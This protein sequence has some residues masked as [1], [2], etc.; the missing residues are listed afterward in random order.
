MIDRQANDKSL[1]F[2]DIFQAIHRGMMQRGRLL[3]LHTPLGENTLIPLRA[4][5]WSKVG[6]GYGWVVDVASTRNDIDG[7]ELMHQQVSLS[8]Q[9][10]TQIYA[11]VEYR[12]VHGFVR[13]FGSIGY[14]GGLSLYQLEFQSA[15]FFLEYARDENQWFDMTAR[16]IVSDLLNKYPQL[17]GR[18]RFALTRQPVKRSYTRQSETDLNFLHRILESEGWYFYWDHASTRHDDHFKGAT[19][20]V[21]DSVWSL[22]EAR[23]AEFYR[24]GESDGTDG[25]T[26]W[27]TMQTA[28]SM[29]YASTSTNYKNIEYP[30][31]I[32]RERDLST[33]TYTVRQYRS[34][35]V[36]SVPAA[37]ME[38]FESLSYGYPDSLAGNRHAKIRTEAW[39]SAAC[40][41]YGLGGM[42]WTDAGMRFTLENHPRHASADPNDREFVAIEV[43]SVIEN[44]IP[45]GHGAAY[46]LSL[47]DM[48]AT[49]K[50]IHGNRFDSQAH[51]VDGARG[52][53]L[54]EIEAQRTDLP[55]RSPL[56]HKKPDMH[57]EHALVCAPGNE[58][59]W[60]DGR[61]RIYVRFRWD[62]RSKPGDSRT[63][64]PLLSLQADTGNG[65]GS[66]HV[67]RAGEWVIV[68]FWGNDC[69]RPY[70]LG[71]LY[72]STSS[73]QWHDNALLSG[74]R[75]RGFGNTGYFNS[76]VQDD[77]THQGGQRFT[78]YSNGSYSLIHQGYLIQHEGNVRG[79]Y[80]GMGIKIH[81]DDYLAVGANKGALI[82]TYHRHYDGEQ[83]D[84]TEVCRQ[85]IGSTALMK[86]LSEASERSQAGSMRT[87]HEALSLFVDSMRRPV[88]P[89][90][91]GGRTANGGTGTANAFKEP[92][93]AIAGPA[94]I[95]AST[96]K[97]I[98]YTADRN[99]NLVSC[100][101]TNIASGQS[102][103]VA[104]R[105]LVSLF[106][107][108]GGM[109]F[110]AN[111]GDVR[112]A[113]HTGAIE[114]LAQ[115]AIKLLSIA[116]KIEMGAKGEIL[117]TAG[118]AYIRLKG[119]DIELHA[120]GK[121]DFKG[122]SFSFDGPK[123]LDYPLPVLA[124]NEVYSGWFKAVDH[125]GRP[126]AGIRYRIQH[127]D[128]S[129]VYYGY[130]DEEGRTLAVT[131]AL[132]DQLH[133]VWDPDQFDES[134]AG[135]EV[136]T[137]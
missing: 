133:V 60:T 112:T 17:Q 123:R 121:L 48:L 100:R 59:A 28:Q 73:P 131:A 95:S 25:L 61:N 21:V 85:I 38:V 6:R 64:P 75:S 8:I 54:V 136:L 40:R 89:Q 99:I 74:F 19:L 66:V 45:I 13:R 4:Q 90:P 55:Y 109:Q 43:R 115:A 24:G 2:R 107:Q 82:T 12:A 39:D 137:C 120:P 36:R 86:S 5:G 68:G 93:I 130:T 69:D 97:S 52:F 1:T 71:R 117:M 18:F 102:L 111:K 125:A 94:G 49:V 118:G 135:D 114:L 9:Q 80:V 127:A 83:L 72:G 26:R 129:R 57:T 34:D 132:A 62:R 76:I 110:V 116:D 20:V 51:I 65:Y 14:D 67:P 108:N 31:S 106:A 91:M 44:N 37:P 77:A 7:R 46:P 23:R 98:H 122:A 47:Q 33:V 41:Y 87:G 27:A 58:E 104:A 63:S 103:N 101:D 16:E 50:A 96:Q 92:L 56:Q 29:T 10:F 79:R 88:T 22:P 134:G 3:M 124:T 30:Y 81:T 126:V 113:T 11:D 78:S 119:G 42:R 35:E 53:H 105:E 32:L 15:L 128:G 70:V 84:V